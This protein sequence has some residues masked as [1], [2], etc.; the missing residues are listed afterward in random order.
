M[1]CETTERKSVTSHG[2]ICIAHCCGRRTRASIYSIEDYQF[3]FLPAPS[4][5]EPLDGVDPVLRADRGAEDD[6]DENWLLTV[7]PDDRL[8]ALMHA[9]VF[10]VRRRASRSSSRCN[11]QALR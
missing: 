9:R 5:S 1:S 10:I 8:A 7:Y 3:R 11:E 2:Q 4:V 6:S